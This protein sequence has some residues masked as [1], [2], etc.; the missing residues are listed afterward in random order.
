MLESEYEVEIIMF[1]R[2]SFDDFDIVD[3]REIDGKEM[4]MW[5]NLKYNWFIGRELVYSADLA[6]NHNDNK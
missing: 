6:G 5:I 4:S 3:V 1:E 2:D